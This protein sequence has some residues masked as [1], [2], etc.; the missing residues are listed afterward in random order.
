MRKTK[1]SILKREIIARVCKKNEVQEKGMKMLHEDV[2][3]NIVE[4][5]CTRSEDSCGTTGRTVYQ[6]GD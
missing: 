4:R 6:H 2:G 5:L 1:V 3:R